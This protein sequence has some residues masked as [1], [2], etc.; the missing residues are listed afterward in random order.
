MTEQEQT[1]PKLEDKLMDIGSLTS[2]SKDLDEAKTPSEYAQIYHPASMLLGGEEKYMDVLKELTR[3]SSYAQMTISGGAQIR[4]KEIKEEYKD[5][6]DRITKEV[7]DQMDKSLEG[8]KTKEEAAT[9][10]SIYLEDLFKFPGLSQLTADKYAQD[11]LRQSARIPYS[12]EAKGSI[13]QYSDKH[14]SLQSRTATSEFLSGDEDKG[15]SI[16]R[17]KL[18]KI[19][20]RVETGATI[21]N[22]AKVIE[23]TEAKMKEAQKTK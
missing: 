3:D 7:A 1:Q 21:Y 13:E 10:V 4:A 20:D 11:E 15:Y 5:Q 9:K 23:M 17:E 2:L 6:K 12:F 19:M 18:G 16:D 22:K 8:I 14:K